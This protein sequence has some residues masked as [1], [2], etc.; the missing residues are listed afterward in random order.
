MAFK[1]MELMRSSRKYKQRREVT[2]IFGE[3]VVTEK[4]PEEPEKKNRE[5]EGKPSDMVLQQ[6][7][8]DSCSGN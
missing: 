7:K 1:A 3:Q 8:E 4:P 2:S 5:A 6:P